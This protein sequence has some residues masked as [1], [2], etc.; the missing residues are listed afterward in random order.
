MA[1]CRKAVQ[2]NGTPMHLRENWNLIQNDE[3]G[4]STAFSISHADRNSC[5]EY[6]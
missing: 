6:C 5:G 1:L 4:N 2:A 3:L